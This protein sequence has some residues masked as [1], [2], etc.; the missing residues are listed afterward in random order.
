MAGVDLSNY[1]KLYIDTAREYINNLSSGC[2]NLAGQ[3]LDKDTLNQL[4]IS[5]HS[6]A[7][8][9][10]FMGYTNIVKLARS[11]EKISKDAMDRNLQL[12][13]DVISN[14]N[15]AVEELGLLLSELDAQTNSA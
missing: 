12:T 13:D 15:K 11:I 9:S 1:K 5:A 10:D 14:I 2:K 4:Y 8:Q 3:D 7:G 6:L